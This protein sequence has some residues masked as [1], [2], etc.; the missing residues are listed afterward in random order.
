MNRIVH[1]VDIAASPGAVFPAARPAMVE[2][3]LPAPLNHQQLP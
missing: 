3:G 1:V 2:P